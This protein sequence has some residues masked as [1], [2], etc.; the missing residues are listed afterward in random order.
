MRASEVAN[1]KCLVPRASRLPANPQM[2]E[3]RCE[4]PDQLQGA[5]L[6]YPSAWRGEGGMSAG[7]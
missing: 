5:T 3:P 2:E 7:Q 1:F 6:P 4:K